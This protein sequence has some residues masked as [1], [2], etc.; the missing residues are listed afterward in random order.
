M[1]ASVPKLVFMVGLGGISN[2]ATS[3]AINAGAQAADTTRQTSLWAVTLFV[4]SALLFVK[5]KST[6]PPL[7]LPK[8]RRSSTDYASR[9]YG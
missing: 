4:V 9:V 1:H 8:S 6:S 2:A 3:P 5:T 7:L